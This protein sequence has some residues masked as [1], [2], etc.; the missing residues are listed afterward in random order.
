MIERVRKT[1]AKRAL[2]KPV[3]EYEPFITTDQIQ[4]GKGKTNF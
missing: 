4:E 2:F 3:K 1:K